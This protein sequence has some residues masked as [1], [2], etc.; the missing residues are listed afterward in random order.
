MLVILLAAN[1]Y[2][3]V[4]AK[5]EREAFKQTT[6]ELNQKIDDIQNEDKIYERDRSEKLQLL[7]TTVKQSDDGKSH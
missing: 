7:L 1:I 5:D 4:Q 3:Y 6:K 2:Q